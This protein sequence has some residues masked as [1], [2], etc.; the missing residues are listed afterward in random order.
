[1]AISES[2]QRKANTAINAIRASSLSMEMQDNLVDAIES[3][4]ETTNGMTHAEKVQALSENQFEM[5]RIMIMHMLAEHKHPSHWKEVI[6]ECKRELTII[7]CV[8]G[9]IIG[10][11]LWHEPKLA[12]H[13]DPIAKHIMEQ[14]NANDSN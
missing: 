4:K 8:L 2:I 7:I 1:M 14:Q 3:T 10:L 13:I 5:T 11:L 9:L 12:D 6:V